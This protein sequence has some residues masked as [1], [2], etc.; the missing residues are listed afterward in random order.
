MSSPP[1]APLHLLLAMLWSL[2]LLPVLVTQL[3]TLV[4]RWS[5]LL[6]LLGT[7]LLPLRCPIPVRGLPQSLR[8]P[9]LGLLLPHLELLMGWLNLLALL[10]PPLW[11]RRPPLLIR[12]PGNLLE[13]KRIR[14]G[15]LR[16][17]GDSFSYRTRSFGYMSATSGQRMVSI[18]T[19]LRE[20]DG[21]PT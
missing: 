5:K 11:S 20:R 4:L 6:L 8:V 14:P 16:R 15:K 1:Y 17:P 2:F 10:N 19:R 3:R 12:P 18:V 13:V 7:C 21:G 9:L